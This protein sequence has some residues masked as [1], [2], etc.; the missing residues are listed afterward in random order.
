L[1]EGTLLFFVM[2]VHYI[3]MY[4]LLSAPRWGILA[5]VW[6][7]LKWLYV[8]L[9]T[10]VQPEPLSRVLDDGMRALAIFVAIMIIVPPITSAIIEAATQR[11]AHT[12]RVRTLFEVWHS[13]RLACG[14]LRDV[15][16]IEGGI[17]LLNLAVFIVSLL[18]MLTIGGSA[19]IPPVMIPVYMWTRGA[20]MGQWIWKNR[21]E[22]E[23]HETI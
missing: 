4:L 11:Y 15:A 3:P 21:W 12:G 1:K 14:D 18:L 19:F 23:P 16:R 8:T 9:F 6:R 10:D 20:L 13:I 5:A 22:E 17:I 2:V 7:I